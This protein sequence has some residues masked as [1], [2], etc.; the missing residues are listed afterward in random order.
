M[1]EDEDAFGACGFFEEGD[2][3]R[4]EECCGGGVVVPL[5]EGGV[6]GVQGETFFVDGEGG[7]AVPAVVD[8]HFVGVVAGF[9]DGF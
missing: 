3:F 2:D 6:E 1:V 5:V 9:V 8:G 4:V 7:G